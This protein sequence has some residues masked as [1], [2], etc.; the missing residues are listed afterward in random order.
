MLQFRMIENEN[1]LL[2]FSITM[3]LIFASSKS[4]QVTPFFKETPAAEI[5]ALVG[6]IKPS[7]KLAPNA[8]NTE[9]FRE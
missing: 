6:Q 5:K 9:L 3:A 7:S 4:K 1:I 8:E 2:A